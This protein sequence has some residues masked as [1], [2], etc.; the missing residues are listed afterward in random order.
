MGKAVQERQVV[1]FLGRI[2][3]GSNMSVDVKKGLQNSIVV[4]N[5]T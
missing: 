3:T 4:P 1:Q 5:L 2:M